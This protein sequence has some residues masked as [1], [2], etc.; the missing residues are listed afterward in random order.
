M[1]W[2]RKAIALWL[3]IYYR[4]RIALL[5]PIV[6]QEALAYTLHDSLAP[7]LVLKI[8][9][10][11][12]GSNVR[13]GRWLVIHESRGSFKNLEIGSDVFIGKRVIIDLTDKVKI[14][15]RCAIGMDVRI[16]THSNF[17]QSVLSGSYPP[18]AAGVEIMDDAIVNWGCIVLKGTLIRERSITLPGSVVSGTLRSDAVYVGNPAR[19][20][21]QK[22]IGE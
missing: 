8:G 12:L 1:N 11:K 18:Q 3:H 21:P 4:I 17:G 7:G 2:M 16:I 5:K 13:V 20:L 6:G 19:I 15:N 10:A 9:G 22:Q 14:G